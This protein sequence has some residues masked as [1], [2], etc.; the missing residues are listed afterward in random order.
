MKKLIVLIAAL[1]LTACASIS[2]ELI[3]V[4]GGITT[5]CN[6]ETKG[7]LS[8][9]ESVTTCQSFDENGVHLEDKDI[10]ASSSA[11]Y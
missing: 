7:T 6:I 2:Q 9:A 5:K 4:A 11:G 8:H 10:T 1:S 3:T